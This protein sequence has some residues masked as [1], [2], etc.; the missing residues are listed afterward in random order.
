MAVKPPRPL[1]G[2]AADLAEFSTAGFGR[3][4]LVE[5][6]RL[7][8]VVAALEDGQEIPLHAPALDLVMAIME[9]TGRVTA[10]DT[11]FSVRGGD[12]VVVP[13]GETRGLRAT[14]GRL[15]AVNVVSPPPGSG[16]HAASA[17]A[18]P[19]DEEAPDVAALILEEHGGLFGRLE[20]LGRL[21]AEVQTLD[22]AA[23]RT[24]LAV[25]LEFLRDGL[26]PHAKEEERS[27]YPAVD[28]VLRAVGGATKTMTIDHRFITEMIDELE[29]ISRGPFS[30]P[31]CEQT[32]RLLYGLQSLLKAHF[33]KENEAYAPL[34]NRLS[35]AE[36]RE[37]H[38]HLSGGEHGH[39][40]PKEV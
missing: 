20:D 17:S 23:R 21:A 31:V 37:L 16:D 2:R 28:R 11:A 10:G 13:A 36:R 1:V 34:L 3:R 35:P 33:T 26:L 29:G 38:D 4:T 24:R 18:W 39:H 32:S 6:Q 40:H 25:A 7:R 30:E 19:A 14:G 9:G 22:E 15:V 12:V 8:V 27:V 5:T